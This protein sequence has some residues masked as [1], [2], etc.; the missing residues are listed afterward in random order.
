MPDRLLDTLSL[1]TGLSPDD[2]ANDLQ[3]KVNILRWLVAKGI[4]DVHQIGLLMSR[5]YSGKLNPGS[6]KL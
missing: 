4:N 6:L 5:F 3:E 2:I 1:Y